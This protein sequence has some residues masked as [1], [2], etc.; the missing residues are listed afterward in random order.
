MAEQ[1]VN[2]AG[3]QLTLRDLFKTDN[4]WLNT[5]VCLAIPFVLQLMMM[6]AKDLY[7]PLLRFVKKLA[8]REAERV[9]EYSYWETLDSWK[10]QPSSN[11]NDLLQKAVHL[12]IGHLCNLEGK[13]RLRLDAAKADF[14]ALDDAAE[15]F[16]N[17][18]RRS[19]NPWSAAS[20]EAEEN[21]QLAQLRKYRVSHSPTEDEWVHLG[22]TLRFCINLRERP[23]NSSS[24]GRNSGGDGAN[25]ITKYYVFRATNPGGSECIEAFMNAA[26]AWYSSR[27]VQEVDNSR[28]LYIPRNEDPLTPKADK[29]GGGDG[30]G[31]RGGP[32]SSH[33][34][35]YRRYKLSDNKTFENIFLPQKDQLLQLI[36]SFKNKTNKVS[37][38]LR[39]SLFIS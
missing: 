35:I 22:P 14:T 25:K 26:L 34:T 37:A 21:S 18:A 19:R 23:Q 28:Y 5:I 31:K 10:A 13:E 38:G 7:Y 6:S 4:V 15:Q 2:N 3:V 16:A 30:P 11:R 39:G 12:Y 8:R 27:L 36:D 9:I 1:I 33:S 17:A 29:G 20:K 32:P 24:E